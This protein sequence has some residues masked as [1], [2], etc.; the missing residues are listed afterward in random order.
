[1]MAYICMNMDIHRF[2][3]GTVGL[4]MT[5]ARKKKYWVGWEGG[6]ERIGERKKEMHS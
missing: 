3:Y 5:R 6:R 1:M 4:G 2:S